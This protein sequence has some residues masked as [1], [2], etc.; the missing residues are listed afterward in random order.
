MS[1][2]QKSN[3]RISGKKS[4]K[5]KK[6]N[7]VATNS[8]NSANTKKL[9]KPDFMKV[10]QA[11]EVLEVQHEPSELY[12]L[13]CAL[14]ATSV[15]LTEVAWVNSLA[16]KE[17][18]DNQKNND[19]QKVLTNFFNWTQSHVK[20]ISKLGLKKASQPGKDNLLMFM[21]DINKDFEGALFSLVCLAQ[22]FLAGLNLSDINTDTQ[23]DDDMLEPL[24]DLANIACL[25]DSGE[26]NS[27]SNREHLELCVDFAQSAI[28]KLVVNCANKFGKKKAYYH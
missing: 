22:G 24:E 25:D 5:S 13:L 19:A 14:F 28:S 7:S 11:L 16:S 2:K 27:E 6:N 9:I 20:N 4:P 26:E 23:K 8:T 18:A 10:Q 1:D 21:P 3:K 17:L 15:Q 12:G